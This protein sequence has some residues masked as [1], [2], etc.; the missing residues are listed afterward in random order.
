[1]KSIVLYARLDIEALYTSDFRPILD[2]VC[3][4]LETGEAMILH[5]EYYLQYS[6]IS[7]LP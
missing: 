7:L 3:Y 6:F 2:L 5:Q 4:L 1:M